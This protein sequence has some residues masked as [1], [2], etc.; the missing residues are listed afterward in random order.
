MS[1][2]VGVS[3]KGK[4]RSKNLLNRII[5]GKTEDLKESNYSRGRTEVWILCL[6]SLLTMKY[7]FRIS[8]KYVAHPHMVRIEVT[9]SRLK[10]AGSQIL[11]TC[12]SNRKCGGSNHA[13]CCCPVFKTDS[14]QAV[15][16]ATEV[17]DRQISKTRNPVRVPR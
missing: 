3:L 2:H 14:L 7:I 13:Q 16:R 5:R 6:A 9:Q 15:V 1:S 10:L 8:F 11:T 17:R 12:D 4:R